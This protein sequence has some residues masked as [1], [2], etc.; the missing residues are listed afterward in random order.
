MA[1]I[2]S[3]STLKKSTFE[4]KVNISFFCYGLPKMVTSKQALFTSQNLIWHAIL[5]RAL[6]SYAHWKEFHH[7]HLQQSLMV[8]LHPSD[9]GSQFFTFKLCH[10]FNL[11]P[12]YAFF[13]VDSNLD[14]G[15]HEEKLWSDTFTHPN[16]LPFV[17]FLFLTTRAMV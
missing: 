2:F 3:P 16:I 11:V 12:K 17:I 5:P 14:P 1:F 7:K 8:N 15:S 4:R 10:T 6:H 9:N 13:G